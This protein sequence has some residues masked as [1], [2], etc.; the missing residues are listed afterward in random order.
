MPRE[1]YKCVQIFITQLISPSVSLSFLTAKYIYFTVVD[2]EWKTTSQLGPKSKVERWWVLWC[3][4]ALLTHIVCGIDT[5]RSSLHLW[6]QGSFVPKD[7]SYV[8]WR[9]EASH[10]HVNKLVNRWNESSRSV[11]TRVVS[12]GKKSR[13]DEMRRTTVMVVLGPE[14]RPKVMRQ[15]KYALYFLSTCFNGNFYIFLCPLCVPFKV[16]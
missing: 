8:K 1:I 13:S 2:S 3:N 11:V 6:Y 16:F 14:S 12:S 15:W 7:L 5:A 9:G 4:F 10:C